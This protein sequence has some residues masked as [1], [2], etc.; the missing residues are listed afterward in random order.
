MNKFVC[1]DSTVNY[2]F[3][4]E[5]EFTKL[6]KSLINEDKAYR[7]AECL[8]LMIPSMMQPIEKDDWFVGRRSYRLLAISPIFG[9][10]RMD[11]AG[12]SADTTRMEKL[13]SNSDLDNE[14]RIMVEDMIT[15]WKKESC[16]PNIRSHFSEVMKQHLPY[17]NW[18]KQ[19]A[20]A[21]P[22]YRLAGAQLDFNKLIKLGFSGLIKE[23]ET[24]KSFSNLTKEQIYFLDGMI[25]VLNLMID[26][27][28]TYEKELLL[29]NSE[30]YDDRTALML[31]TVRNL[32][33]SAPKSFH[34]ALLIVW[35]YMAFSGTLDFGRCDDFFG[36]LYVKDIDSENIT[37]DTALSY[38]L[39]FYKL[40]K[41]VIGRD[42]R[43]ILGG[44]GRRNPDN[45]DRFAILAMKACS[46]HHEA[47]PQLSLR[48][49]EGMSNKV[50][51]EA[52]N[53]LATKITYPLLFNDESSIDAVMKMMHVPYEEAEQYCF[54][55]C[56]E[57]VINHKSMGTP[58]AIINLLK[59]L[60][61]TLH[62][63]YDQISGKHIGLKTGELEKFD[64][65]EKLLDAYRKQAEF[66]TVLSADAQKLI[67]NELNNR[68]SMLFMSILNDDCIERAQ[69]VL[70]GGIRYL[71]GTYETY[72][73]VSVSDS[74]LAIKKSVYEEKKFTLKELV[75]I[76]DNDFEGYEEERRYLLSLPKYGNE[77]EEAEEMAKLIDDHIC[78]FTALQAQRV[79]LSSFLVVIIN[80][81]ANTVLGK[82]T[83]ASAD[84]RKAF[85]YMSNGN[86][87][88]AGAD[89]NGLTAMLNSISIPDMSK[90]AGAAQ[91]IKL[92][93]DLFTKHR[94]KLHALIDTI[95]KK[96][97]LSLSISVVNSE[98]LQQAMIHPELYQNLFVRVGGFSARFVT[99]NEE[100]KRDMLNRTLYG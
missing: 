88:M 33:N 25:S 10:D 66:F 59:T 64:T 46:I 71:G 89:K 96:G 65:F 67:Y 30:K 37:E 83:K 4:Y 17:D 87:P 40:S 79:G 29:Q 74:L 9:A 38:L 28:K 23:I 14:T 24:R 55:G 52:M 2:D 72:G 36:D 41:E 86:C 45:A 56:G 57:Y 13:L 81:D 50:R 18:E 1:N 27:L 93:E 20:A 3:K 68:A 34:E 82:F 80:N 77:I 51:D 98:D 47:K 90:T 61:I 58:N 84:G 32:Q 22:L 39:S 26:V 42:T 91:N 5:L 15:F 92:N 7:E 97:L 69:A 12:Y 94:A 54:F 19:S 62:N 49:Y 8:K 35:L 53:L 95:F 100:V 70:D 63:G 44:K 75:N 99:L 31:Q 6:Y 43:I 85:T 11:N 60:E 76:L 73:N 21:F 78:D 48:M 16:I